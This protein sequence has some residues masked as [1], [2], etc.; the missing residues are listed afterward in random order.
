MVRPAERVCAVQFG[1][2]RN[3]MREAIIVAAVRTPKGRRNGTI[4]DRKIE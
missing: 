1:L 2:R 3:G 4:I